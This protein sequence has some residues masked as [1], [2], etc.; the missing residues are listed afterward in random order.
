MQ[1]CSLKPGGWWGQGKSLPGWRK[2]G[3]S[4]KVLFSLTPS[5]SRRN[6]SKHISRVRVGWCVSSKVLGDFYKIINRFICLPKALGALSR[7]PG[8]LCETMRRKDCKN[9]TR[10][11]DEW[12][13]NYS[14]DPAAWL[15]AAATVCAGLELSPSLESRSLCWG[16]MWGCHC[17]LS[18]LVRSGSCITEEPPT[19]MWF[20]WRC[21]RFLLSIHSGE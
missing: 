2:Q 1:N 20:W 8:I 16:V 18:F 13:I 7:T 3:A 19:W 17:V 4:E 21:G 12:S 5:I 6:S 14:V 9:S 10:F 15:S 11:F